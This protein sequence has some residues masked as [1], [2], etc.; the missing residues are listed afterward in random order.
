MQDARAPRRLNTDFP[1]RES[2][3]DKRER[4][5]RVLA[6]L[7]RLYPNS[8]TALNW[9]NSYQLLVATILS[10]QCT[11]ARVNLVTPELFRQLPTPEKASAASQ[12]QVEKLVQTTGFFRNKA[13]NI[14]GAAKRIV[15]VHG[16]KVPSTME[17]LLALPGVARKTA[18]CV[19]G[20]AFDNP[21]GVVVDTHVGRIARR[22]GF[23]REQNPVKI[24]RD[25]M[26][27]F[28]R[29]NWVYLSH[30]WIDHG[31]AICTA[32]TAKCSMCT[33]AADCPQRVDGRR[34]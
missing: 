3:G 29:R 18:N 30:S 6:E 16:G 34:I 9:D 4:A 5:E 19:L 22:M 8:K 31:R 25:L 23:T 10:A 33:F 20:T 28:P 27:L 24:E 17:E 32:R 2:V 14:R 1:A 15:E 12:E 13:K 7:H 26:K 11:D 21:V